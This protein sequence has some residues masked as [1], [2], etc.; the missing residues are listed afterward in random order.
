V[1]LIGL[2]FSNISPSVGLEGDIMNPVPGIR[3]VA[4]RAGELMPPGSELFVWNDFFAAPEYYSGHRATQLSPSRQLV[5]EIRRIL[6][7]G[8]LGIARF[9]QAPDGLWDMYYEALTRHQPWFLMIQD[10]E[11]VR[12]SP[13][14]PGVTLAARANGWNLLALNSNWTEGKGLSEGNETRAE[15]PVVGVSGVSGHA[16]V[17]IVDAYLSASRYFARKGDL[18][19]AARVMV[20]LAGAHPDKAAKAWKIAGALFEKVGDAER[21][22]NA[23]SRADSLVNGEK[24]G[25]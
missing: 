24:R 10:R 25:E 19:R 15:N 16:P 3:D 8:K 13:G 12:L 17:A 21:A 1:G 20:E 14:F 18:R 7:V 23:F 6:V 9:V 22:R 11:L 5:D 4:S 2:G